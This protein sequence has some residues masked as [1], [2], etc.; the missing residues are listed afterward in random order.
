MF[1]DGAL[2]D[3]R[4]EWVPDA[5]PGI[6]QAKEDSKTVLQMVAQQQAGDRWGKKDP[7]ESVAAG[8]VGSK[9]HTAVR[10]RGPIQRSA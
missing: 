2:N 7:W 4:S 1:S 9:P 3:M 8:V 6:D 10:T 5:I